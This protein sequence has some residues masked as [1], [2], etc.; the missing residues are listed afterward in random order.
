MA[1][2][3][4]AGRGQHAHH[5]HP[6]LAEAAGTGRSGPHDLGTEPEDVTAAIGHDLTSPGTPSGKLWARATG[7]SAPPEQEEG[8]EKPRRFEVRGA[9][10][11]SESR[12]VPRGTSDRPLGTDGAQAADVTNTTP[13]GGA[14][15]GGQP[16]PRQVIRPA[17]AEGSPENEGIGNANSAL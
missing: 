8:S 5:E 2:D 13:P 17:G 3:K 10:G 12:P 14:P 1:R 16:P 6:H 15:G 9:A 11:G 7:E 4:E